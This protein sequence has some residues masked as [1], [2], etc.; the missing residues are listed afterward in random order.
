[1]KSYAPLLSLS[2]L[3]SVIACSA[4][5]GHQLPGATGGG[6]NG[7]LILGTGGNGPDLTVGPG[8]GT[9]DPNDTRKVPIRQKTCDAAGACTCLR[10]ALIGTLDS[11][12]ASKDTQPFLDWLN[13]NSGG[14]ATV[15]MV[16][17]QPTLDDAFLKQYDILVIANVNGWTFSAADKTAV[18]N[19]VRTTGG[20]I[21]SLTGFVSIDATEPAAT[22]QL[23]EFSGVKYDS[24]RTALQGPGQKTPVYYNGGSVDLKTCLSWNGDNDSI[25]TASVN[26]PPQTGQLSKLTFGLSYAGAFLGYG[27]VAPA[28]ATVIA[29]DPTTTENIAVAYEVDGTGRIFAW[30][31]EWVIYAN[32]WAPKTGA[33]P[34]NTTKDQGNICYDA[35]LTTPLPFHSVQTLYQTKQFWYDAINWVA[36]PNE[37]NFVIVDDDVQIPK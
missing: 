17:T 30:G 25:I 23:I 31:D 11:A 13:G 33:T 7:G 37:C 2:F 28:G 22:S 4:G 10:L 12:A 8:T 29:K 35:T 9:S 21:I 15:T 34:Y 32:Q 26:F 5:A 16:K 19:W 1:M 3:A 18:E 20:G 6:G 24:N 14:T 27:V 36:P